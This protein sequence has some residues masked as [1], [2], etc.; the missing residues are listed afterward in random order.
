MA[1]GTV[2]ERALQAG[3]GGGSKELL[4]ETC[5]P[6]DVALGAQKH[7]P[8]KNLRGH[9]LPFRPGAQLSSREHRAQEVVGRSDVAVMYL[10]AEQTGAGVAVGWGSP[11]AWVLMPASLAAHCR[12]VRPWDTSPPQRI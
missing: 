9:S 10:W 2:L 8:P 3:A 12:Q 4:L 5:S 11:E 7:S 1:L 6:G